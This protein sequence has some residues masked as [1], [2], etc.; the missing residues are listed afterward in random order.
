MSI[1]PGL[2]RIYSKG[3]AASYFHALVFLTCIGSLTFRNDLAN[4]CAFHRGPLAAAS[5]SL[6]RVLLIDTAASIVVRLWKA[7]RHAQTA[8]LLTRTD[9]SEAAHPREV[10][11]PLDVAR[12]Q[13]H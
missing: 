11:D 10:L 9:A 13:W 7:Y 4:D 3:H 6:G 2:K 12:M 5:D 8:W 1:L